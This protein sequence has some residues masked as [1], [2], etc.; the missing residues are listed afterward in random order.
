MAPPNVDEDHRFPYLKPL[1]ELILSTIKSGRAYL[2]FCL[3]HQL[4]AHVLGCRVGP[5]PQKSVGFITG[6]LTPRGLVHPAFQ[7][8]PQHLELFKWHG[9]GV[10]LP[11]PPGLAILATSAA[12]RVEALGLLDNPR[13]VGLQFDNHAGSGDVRRWLEQD[14]EWALSGSGPDPAGMLAR[15]GSVAPEMGRLFRRFLRNFCLTAGFC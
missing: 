12:A 11:V 10:Q 4:L 3:G 14:K 9:Q 5:L 15:A 7:G 13:V 8:L 2:G 1:K 6:R